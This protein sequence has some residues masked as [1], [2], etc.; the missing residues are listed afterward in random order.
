[1]RTT[2]IKIRNLFG[3]TETELDG[4]SVELTGA[5]GVGKTSVIDALRYALT[6]KSDRDIIVRQGE[7]EGEI[8]IE[9]D[10]GLSIDRKKRTEQADYKSVKEN[11]KEVMAPENFLRQLFTPLQL[12]PVAFTLMDAKS[13]NRAILD[14][15][16]YDWD[17]NFINDKFGEIPSWINYE[18]NILEVLSDMQSENGQWFKER[19]NVNRDIRN[20]QAFIEDIAKDIPADYQAEKWETYDLGAAYKKLEQIKEHN[21]RIERARLFRSSYDSK[22][23]KLEADKMI[24]ISAEEKAISTERETLLSDIERMKAQIKASEDKL[25]GLSGKL[26]DKKALAESRF[27]EAKTKLD[28]DMSVAD[29]YTDK[30]PIDFAELQKEVENA[31]EMKRHLNEYSRMKG[32]Q[33]EL[34]EL[35]AQSDEYTRKIEL[36][37]TL[38]GEILET[39]KIPI[40]GF[41]VQNGIP[42]ING[43]P[44]ANLSEGEQLSLCVDV[45][46]S[47]PN[48]LQVI[49]I[50][51]TEKLSSE[52]REKLYSK[53][54]EKGIQFIATR[55]TDSSE[56]E[57][58]YI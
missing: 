14:L 4:R 43:L 40:E 6:N 28:A 57:V 3:I 56:M 52:N 50:D 53:C 12:D 19:Q 2:K 20:K 13:K 48:G 7:K 22:L 29:E 31:E 30:Q 17:L 21:S 15:I 55:T 33:S 16:E 47:K 39:A 44:V 5:N 58:H 23:R 35:K 37:R 54:H 24:E 9:T 46:I 8:L 38:P 1:M 26:E 51:G 36:A 27:N 45:A 41:T 32:M 10:T 25:A 42:L 18:Q 34:E 49:L 11:G